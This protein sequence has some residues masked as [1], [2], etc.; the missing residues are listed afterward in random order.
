MTLSLCRDETAGRLQG[1]GQRCEIESGSLA[2][3]IADDAL[4]VSE[5]LGMHLLPLRE[6]G[7]RI[8]DPRL[9]QHALREFTLSLVEALAQ[10]RAR[11]ALPMPGDLQSVDA[12]AQPVEAESAADREVRAQRGFDGQP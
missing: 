2:A 5:L 3:Q 7:S 6:R 4:Q 9:P 10:A 1:D 11:D 8:L 12:P